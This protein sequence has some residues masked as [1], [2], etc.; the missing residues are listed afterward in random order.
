MEVI[1]PSDVKKAMDSLIFFNGGKIRRPMTFSSDLQN[2][3]RN[4]DR[5]ANA[6]VRRVA[7]AAF[8]EIN[9]ASPE[10][11]GTFR[12]NWVV[13]FDTIDRTVDMSRNKKDIPQSMSIA[14]AAIMGNAELGTVIYICNSVPYAIALENGYSS[15]ASEGV[16][17]PAI[18]AIR[19]A[20]ESGRL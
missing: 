1:V 15:Q 19:N 14:T 12:A 20:V 7:L 3:A 18:T 8:R 11:K 9:K 4:F 2:A 13:S 6:R 17:D 10:D 16:V 5:R